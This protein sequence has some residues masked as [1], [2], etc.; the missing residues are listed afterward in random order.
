AGNMFSE[1]EMTPAERRVYEEL[2][3]D[4]FEQAKTKMSANR[5]SKFAKP[6]SQLID[7]GPYWISNEALAA[8]LVDELIYLDQLKNQLKE[9]FGYKKT[10]KKM[11]DYRNYTWSRQKENQI[12]VIYAQ[13]NIV[14]GKGT[15]GQKIAHETT[16]EQIRK[17]RKN[18]DYKGII[19]RID[20][21]GGSAQASDIIWRE[22]ELAKIEN[23]KPIVV[24][25]SG[26]AASG[27]TI[28]PVMQTK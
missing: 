9:D 3:G 17:A 19:L 25:M 28:L 22:L 7:E 18:K 4:I 1:K 12:A 10:A 20:S 13:G 15:P 14:M 24:S 5:G 26:V 8:G 16:V 23:K 11:D 21:G 27:D 6:I 2:L